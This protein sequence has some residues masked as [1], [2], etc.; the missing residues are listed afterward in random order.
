MSILLE[1]IHVII[2]FFQNGCISHNKNRFCS[3]AANNDP[4]RE[5]KDILQRRLDEKS[6]KIEITPI[7]QIPKRSNFDVRSVL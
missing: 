5:V 1:F 2:F 4:S 6:N 7:S 3:K